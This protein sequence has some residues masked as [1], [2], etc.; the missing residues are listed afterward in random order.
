MKQREWHFV[1]SDLKK[2]S[3][4]GPGLGEA[5]KPVPPALAE[6]FLSSA[7]GLGLGAPC[8][9]KESSLLVQPQVLPSLWTPGGGRDHL[10]V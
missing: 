2:K 8:R 10:G 4:F 9:T 7:A 1:V 6:T 5:P 3:P